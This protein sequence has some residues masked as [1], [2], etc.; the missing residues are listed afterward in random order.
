M[1][2][3]ILTLGAAGL[4]CPKQVNKRHFL[5]LQHAAFQELGVD[6]PISFSQP[7]SQRKRKLP[8]ELQA[9]A[10][11]SLGKLSIQHE[12]MAKQ[13]CPSSISFRFSVSLMTISPTAYSGFGS[14]T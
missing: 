13:V 12:E 6:A 5:L 4:H 9:A 3:H 7:Q 11:I 14:S 2:R 1:S 10:I 8:P